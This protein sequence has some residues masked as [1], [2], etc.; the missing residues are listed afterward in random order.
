MPNLQEKTQAEESYSFP[1]SQVIWTN[2]TGA[3]E[4]LVWLMTKY[5][6]DLKVQDPEVRTE[7][8]RKMQKEWMRVP[9]SANCRKAQGRNIS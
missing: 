7:T 6:P 4:A 1:E 5:C 8:E 9:I 3:R 2:D